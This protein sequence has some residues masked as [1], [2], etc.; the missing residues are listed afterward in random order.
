LEYEGEGT[1][2]D[3]E[4]NEE[5]IDVVAGIAWDVLDVAIDAEVDIFD[6]EDDDVDE[7]TL[8]SIDVSDDND[9]ELELKITKEDEQNLN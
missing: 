3:E 7:E 1:T 6:D 9:K 8:T 2:C 5:D 4:V